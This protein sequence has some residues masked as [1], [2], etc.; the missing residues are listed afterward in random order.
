MEFLAD[1]ELGLLRWL[2]IL[3][4]VYWLGGEWGVFQ[5]SYKVVDVRLPVAERQRHMDTAYR[6]D[7]M[8]RT[9]IITLLPLG[10]HMGHLWGIQPLG[11]PWLVAMWL[12]WAGWMALTW[13]TFLARGTLRFR[14]LSSLEDWTRYLLIPTLLVVALSSLLGHGPLEAGEGQRW[15]SAKLLT[16]GLALVIGVILRL[17]MHQW[18]ALFPKLAAGPDAAIEARLDRSIRIGRAVAYLYWVLIATACLLA[19]T[20]PF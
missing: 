12:L 2:H 8:A 1:N 19:A 16:Y 6:I 9:G 7:I 4:M 20:K 15:Y 14:A 10:L 17:V 18:Q 13:S 11:G 5:T 3:A